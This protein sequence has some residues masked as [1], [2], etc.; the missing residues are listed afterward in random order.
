MFHTLFIPHVSHKNIFFSAFRDFTLVVVTSKERLLDTPNVFWCLFWIPVY[1]G[2]K[3]YVIL[4]PTKKQYILHTIVYPMFIINYLLHEMN[5]ECLSQSLPQELLQ[6]R[7]AKLAAQSASTPGKIAKKVRVAETTPP[8][9][10]M[11]DT[12]PGDLS[13]VGRKKLFEVGGF[14]PT[15]VLHG[16]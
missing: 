3:H 10:E 12:I 5:P 7:R 1:N 16:F 9:T 6:Q 13:P 11:P 8:Q 2:G 4:L 15:V 14:W